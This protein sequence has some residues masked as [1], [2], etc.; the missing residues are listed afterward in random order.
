MQKGLWIIARSHKQNKTKQSPFHIPIS[1]SGVGSGVDNAVLELQS[2]SSSFTEQ[3]LICT[4]IAFLA[5]SVQD[6]R[7]L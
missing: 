4:I 2:I 1:S 7:E 5:T 6:E 3:E